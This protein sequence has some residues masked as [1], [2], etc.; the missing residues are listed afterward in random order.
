MATHLKLIIPLICLILLCSCGVQKKK[1][2]EHEK[3]FGQDS[4]TVSDTINQSEIVFEQGEYQYY[5]EI[6]PDITVE[7]PCVPDKETAIKIAEAVTSGFQR[8]GY[9]PNYVPQSVFFDT[10]KQLWIVT[11][12]PE[13]DNDEVVLIGSCFSV[14]IKKDNAEVIKMWVGE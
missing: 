9:F 12:A 8:K 10:Q 1:G 11:F 14:A 7:N 6:T 2:N 4:E 3:F 5:G 13:S